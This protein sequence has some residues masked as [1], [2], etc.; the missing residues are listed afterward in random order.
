LSIAAGKVLLALDNARSIK[1]FLY[2]Y[3]GKTEDN[4]KNFTL[5][6]LGIIRTNKMA[7]LSARFTDADEARACFHYS[8]IL[9]RLEAPS[10]TVFETAVCDILNG[11]P[12]ATDFASDI[13]SQAAHRVGLFFE[14]AGDPAMAEALFRF[15]SS[16]ECNE[17]LVRLLYKNG[18]KI[19]ADT[20]V[21]Q[22]IDDPASDE[23]FI[24]ATDFYSRKFGG[25]RTALCTNLLRGGRT[26][27]VDDT[28]RGNPEAGVAVVMRRQGMTVFY[29][30]NTLWLSLFGLLFWDELFESGQIHGGFD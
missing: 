15:G 29:A 21:R 17:R 3:F 30:E 14:K 12:C 9:D 5:R 23:E 26:V 6:D 2:L 7:S 1:F 10:A 22:M 20:L 8:Q 28:H 24:F 19:G 25:Q 4:L 16:P 13:A 18:D 11:P 27:I